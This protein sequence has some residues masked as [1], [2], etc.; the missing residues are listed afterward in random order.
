MQ[1]S[2]DEMSR[3]R[4][5]QLCTPPSSSGTHCH[6]ASSHTLHRSRH[7]LAECKRPLGST[8]GLSILA[9]RPKRPQAASLLAAT[10]KQKSWRLLTHSKNMLYKSG[11]AV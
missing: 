6:T 7:A 2:S 8:L 3:R 9:F 10:N 11:N 4:P 5:V 1:R